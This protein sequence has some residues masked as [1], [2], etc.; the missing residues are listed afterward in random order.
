MVNT[1]ASYR[2]DLVTNLYAGRTVL[3]DRQAALAANFMGHGY[4]AAQAQAAALS[5]LDGIV[6]TQATV[7]AYENAFLVSGVVFVLVLPLVFLLKK[8]DPKAAGTAH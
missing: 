4:G 3:A 5:A 1:A 2:A 7:L 6:Q 8:G